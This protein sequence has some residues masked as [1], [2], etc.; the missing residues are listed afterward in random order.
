MPRRKKRT[1]VAINVKSFSYDVRETDEME[2]KAGELLDEIQPI[3]N[4]W[5]EENGL[6]P[7]ISTTTIEIRN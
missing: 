4:K 5:A 6:T 7:E 3:I 2:H 1:R